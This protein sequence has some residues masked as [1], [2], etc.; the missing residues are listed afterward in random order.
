MMKV[1]SVWVSMIGF[2]SHLPH[3]AASVN[4]CATSQ[5][6]SDISHGFVIKKEYDRD[7]L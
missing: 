7:F 5:L 6:I 2:K 1:F 3:E 4:F